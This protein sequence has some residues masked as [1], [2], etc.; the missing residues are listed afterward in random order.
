M[1]I[2]VSL[3]LRPVAVTATIIATA[4]NEAI[5]P[6]SI[7]VTPSTSLIKFINAFMVKFL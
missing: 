7:A 3:N 2:K 5:Y 1:Y 4:I 6:Y